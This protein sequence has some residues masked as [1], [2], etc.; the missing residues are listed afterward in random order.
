M[1]KAIITGD[2]YQVRALIV[3]ATN[4]I[5]SYGDSKMT[6]Q[7]LKQCEFLVTVDYWMT[8]TAL[9]SDYVFPAAGALERP[10]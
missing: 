5:N 7:A 3:N 6:L 4:P 9:L 10:T 2:P 8:P 1:F